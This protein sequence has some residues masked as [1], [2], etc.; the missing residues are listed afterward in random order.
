MKLHKIIISSGIISLLLLQTV[1]AVDRNL[2]QH[3]RTHAA[4]RARLINKVQD[5]QD[6]IQDIRTKSADTKTLIKGR[7]YN[8]N[9]FKTGHLLINTKNKDLHASIVSREGD[10]DS[11]SKAEIKR[12]KLSKFDMEAKANEINIEHKRDQLKEENDKLN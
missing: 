12:L 1:S 10:K 4:S 3:Q 6:R 7:A 2:T 11:H 8:P 5:Y 9:N